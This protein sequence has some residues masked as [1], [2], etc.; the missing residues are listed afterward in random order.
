M[1][2]WLVAIGLASHVHANHRGTKTTRFALGLMAAGMG[3]FCVLFVHVGMLASTGFTVDAIYFSM[4]A[5]SCRIGLGF[6]HFLYDR[7]VYKL[8]APTV[9]ATIGRD[10]LRGA[11]VLS[12]GRG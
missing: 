7:W 6:V 12:P 1:N 5:V 3:I 10:L 2:H 4:T 11:R 8:S 9:R